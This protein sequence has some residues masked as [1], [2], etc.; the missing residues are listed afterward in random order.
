MDKKKKTSGRGIFLML[1]CTII[2][3]FWPEGANV[4]LESWKHFMR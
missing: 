3:Q 2:S 4:S 1:I